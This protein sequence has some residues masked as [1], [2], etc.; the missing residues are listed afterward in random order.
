MTRGEKP[1]GRF[2]LVAPL[3]PYAIT[4]ERNARKKPAK[5]IDKT[6]KNTQHDANTKTQDAKCNTIENAHPRSI[7]Y[8]IYTK[9]LKQ[10]LENK[11]SILV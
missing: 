8:L 3:F 5:R 11:S 7:K 10:Q 1:H 4:A 9:I 2:P 6:R